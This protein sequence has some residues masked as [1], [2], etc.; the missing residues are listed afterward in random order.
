MLFEHRFLFSGGKEVRQMRFSSHRKWKMVVAIFCAAITVLA[1]L[2]PS[3]LIRILAVA[4][5]L[6]FLWRIVATRHVS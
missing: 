3:E 5:D 4:F 2:I 1:I 6:F